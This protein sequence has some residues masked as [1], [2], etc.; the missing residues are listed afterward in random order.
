VGGIKILAELQR[1]QDNPGTGG[2]EGETFAAHFLWFE[3]A[4]PFT[5]I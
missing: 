3:V 4:A 2:G 1:L 5:W